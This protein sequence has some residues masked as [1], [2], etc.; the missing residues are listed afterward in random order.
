MKA[1]V[2]KHV[3]SYYDDDAPTMIYFMT[4]DIHARRAF[5]EEHNDGEIVGIHVKREKA[6]DR[7]EEAGKVPFWLLA[8]MGWWSE[9]DHC[10]QRVSEDDLN[11]RNLDPTEIVGTFC[12]R[13]YCSPV[14]HGLWKTDQAEK[15]HVEGQA[16]FDLEKHLYRLYGD[17]ISITK[18]QAYSSHRTR[19]RLLEHAHVFFTFPGQTIGECRIN[20]R[21]VIQVPAGAMTSYN[22]WREIDED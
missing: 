2:V 20:E 10:G 17:E 18:T 9:C 13:V 6:L 22:A 16:L 4:H 1:F 5:A 3:D 8:L 12:S 15:K 7:Y 21:H 14:C 19:G 11:D